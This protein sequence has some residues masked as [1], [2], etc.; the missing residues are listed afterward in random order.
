[1]ELSVLSYC[2]NL[3]GSFRVVG[4]SGRKR[5]VYY[6]SGIIILPNHS[7]DHVLFNQTKLN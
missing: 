7:A 6:V 5:G 2:L 4:K 1:M 3:D